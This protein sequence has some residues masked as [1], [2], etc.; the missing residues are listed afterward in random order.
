MVF[1]NREAAA[2][3]LAKKLKGFQKEHPLVLAVPR[4]AV[5]MGKIIADAIHGDLDVV[6][7]RKLGAP[8]NPELA[9]GAVSESGAV[10]LGSAAGL[11]ELSK[12]Y[13]QKAAAREMETIRRRRTSYTPVRP[14]FN[15][16]NR[17]V[18]IVDDGIATGATMLSAVRATHSQGARKV[19]VA[20]PVA[21]REAANLLAAEADGTVFLDVPE[22]FWAIS[23]FY[24]EFS[25]VTDE[26]VVRTLEARHGNSGSGLVSAS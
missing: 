6:L 19:I 8:G 2:R 10:Y 20:A 23:Q 14:P 21:S 25:Q 22:E 24:E 17:L 26:E 4:G 5:P 7:V 9:I 11:F 15:P 13:V 1:R 12:E 3:L 16:R 18:I